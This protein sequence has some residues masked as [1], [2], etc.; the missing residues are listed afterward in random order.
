MGLFDFFK[1]K[2]KL[3]PEAAALIEKMKTI[4]FPGGV[5]Q[6]EKETGELHA[7]L[8]GRLTKDETRSLL[9]RTRAFIF[10]T[11]DMSQTC[12]TDS[13]LESTNGKLTQHE[14]ISVY[15]F[16]TGYSRPLSGEIGRA[17]V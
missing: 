15:A 16:L 11:K 10:V 12:I 8:G 1:P 5:R 7:L 9:L 2:P 3:S 14:A 4:A 6:V 17:H 13:I